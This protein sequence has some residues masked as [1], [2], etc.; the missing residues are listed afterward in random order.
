MSPMEKL[1]LMEHSLRATW[2][3]RASCTSRSCQ[4][5]S[6]TFW[7]SLSQ[8]TFETIPTKTESFSEATFEKIL[9]LWIKILSKPQTIQGEVGWNQHNFPRFFTPKDIPAFFLPLLVNH[10]F[11]TMTSFQLGIIQD[12]GLRTYCRKRLKRLRP[13]STS[14]LPKMPY[15]HERCFAQD[16]RWPWA[17]LQGITPTAAKQPKRWKVWKNNYF[18]CYFLGGGETQYFLC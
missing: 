1:P 17:W 4:G 7:E 12:P 3:D 15:V 16:A 6:M 5:R 10:P 14:S 9:T 18:P 11:T 2:K 13:S 8:T